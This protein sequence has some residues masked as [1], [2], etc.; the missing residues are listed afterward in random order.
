MGLAVNDVVQL[1]YQGIYA[2][3]QIRYVTHWRVSTAGSSTTAE[4][5]L[6]AMAANFSLPTNTVTG[7]LQGCHVEDFQFTA[8]SAQRVW[9]LRTVRMNVLSSFPGS[10]IEPGLPP[11]TAVVLTKRTLTPGRQGLGSIH[12]TGVPVSAVQNG[13]VIS[14][15]PY[16]NLAASMA[17]SRS[18]PAVTM[19]VEP[20]LWNPTF[21]PNFFSR[22]F[23]AFLQTTVRTMRRRT[24]QLGI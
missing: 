7:L 18:I 9:P 2:N 1:T 10:I 12:L 23:D 17:A 21:P 19:T 5:D 3:Q 15:T 4:L 16:T 13:V 24:V 14:P 6:D 20:G 8:V 11:N 22:M